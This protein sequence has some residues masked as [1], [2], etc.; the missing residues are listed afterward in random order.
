MS[1]N[2]RAVLERLTEIV[3]RSRRT[4]VADT[5][6]IIRFRTVSGGTPEEQR[7]CDREIPACFA[8]LAE[9]ARTMG[10]DFR[11][12][13]GV[14][15]EIVWRHEDP[16]AP[17]VAIAG[18][19]DVVTPGSA[20][21]THPP[22]DGAV[23]GDHVWGRGAQDDKGP[24]VQALHAMNAVREAGIALPCTVKL[25]IGTMEETGDWSDMATYRRVAEK[26]DYAFTPDADFPIISGEKG[27]LNA[28]IGAEWPRTPVH[29]ET[30]LEFVSLLGGER[31]NVIPASCEF[32]VRFPKERRSEVLRELVRAT[33]EY[34]VEHDEAN[35]TMIPGREREIAEDRFEAVVSFIGRSG[36][37]SSPQKGHNAIL[38]ALDFIRDIET[39]PQPVRNFALLAYAAGSDAW[40]GPLGIALEHP[41]V[42]KTTVCLTIAD[43]RPTGGRV[44]LNVRPTMGATAHQ[45]LDRIRAALEPFEGEM[46]L[47]LTI[48][49]KG[50]T[51]DPIHM[52]ADAPETKPFIDALRT[53]FETVTGRPGKLRA[54]GGTTYAKAIPNCVAFG[55]IL[56]PD[57]PSLIH[58]PD[59]RVGIDAIVRNVRIYALAL[60]LLADKPLRKR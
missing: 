60:A 56:D 50:E 12:I 37:A 41:F 57:E 10:F 58:E 34:V 5:S 43:I 3:E 49:A 32:T 18:H 40:G 8:W 24:V 53:A 51:M 1:G 13:E 59:E 20:Q 26:P 48:E 6:R 4:I 14:V 11:I 17:I 45:T 33:T 7:V 55:P 2:E 15:A 38:D 44:L 28:V 19:I 9:R 31:E 42:G 47:D 35:A 25:V 36:H 21:W 27:M 22:F 16:G 23:N 39:I 54:V 52:D 46:G 29:A 30:G